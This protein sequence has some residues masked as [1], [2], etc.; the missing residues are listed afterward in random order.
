MRVSDLYKFNDPQS[1]PFV[2]VNVLKDSRL[3]VDPRA[4]RLDP[5]PTQYVTDAKTSMTSFFDT[6]RDQSLRA[7]S[8]VRKGST[9]TLSVGVARYV[10][11]ESVA[12]L[13]KRAD[14][15]LYTA[16]RTGRNRVVAEDAGVTSG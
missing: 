14:A 12:D 4:I 6:V 9:I 11:G 13:I 16:K 3:F 8:S 1:L 5:S 7:G 15:G 10:P 2:D